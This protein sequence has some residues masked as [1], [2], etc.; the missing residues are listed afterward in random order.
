[1]AEPFAQAGSDLFAPQ[2]GVLN[3]APQP[4]G[5]QGLSLTPT[6][7]IPTSVLE[8]FMPLYMPR[9]VDI[10]VIATAGNTNWDTLIV[11]SSHTFNAAKQSSGAQNAMIEW[12]VPLSAGTWAFE[13]MHSQDSNRGIYTVTVGS[14][15]I[16]TIDGYSAVTANN[17]RSSTSPNFT[18]S[19]S[20]LYLLALT[21]ATK[22]ASS[23]SFFG[24]INYVKLSR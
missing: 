8:T 7:S 22:N 14:Q 19:Q 1:M 24:V 13:L 10:N 4:T 20:G 18:I 16:G 15:T 9:T 12:F 21:M 11:S 5:G 2:V 6:G 17:V 3:V 23:S